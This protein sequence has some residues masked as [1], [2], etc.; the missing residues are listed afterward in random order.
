M[1]A[2]GEDVPGNDQ[3]PAHGSEM[4]TL[5]G[6]RAAVETAG[7]GELGATVMVLGPM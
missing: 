6:V 4:G 7:F 1:A 2:V 5:Y 3:E